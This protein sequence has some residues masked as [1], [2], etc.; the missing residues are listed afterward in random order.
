ML[1]LKKSSG[2]E[3]PNNY[4]AT[5]SASVENGTAGKNAFVFSVK[6]GISN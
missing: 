6:D 5:D 1:G 4:G 2:D 3:A